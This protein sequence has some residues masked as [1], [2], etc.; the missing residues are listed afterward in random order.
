MAGMRRTRSQASARQSAICRCTPN[1]SL[2][3]GGDRLSAGNDRPFVLAVGANL[4]TIGLGT[5]P[6]AAETVLGQLPATLALGPG[7]GDRLTRHC[8]VGR[9]HHLEF[10]VG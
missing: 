2:R 8:A 7:L 4:E 3:P 10:H 9:E 6:G 1:A 5:L